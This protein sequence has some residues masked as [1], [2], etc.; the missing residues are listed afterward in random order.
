MVYNSFFLRLL[1]RVI[2][3]F[4]SLV[5]LSSIFLRTDLFFTQVILISL[6][7][8]QITELTRFVN[9]TNNELSRFLASVKDGDF[10]ASFSA[11]PGNQS[12]RTLNA[13]FSQLIETLKE[14]ETEKAAQFHFLNQLV[15]Q[16][17]FG[18]I[19]FNDKEEI[20]LMNQQACELL[21]FPKIRNWKNLK[22]PNIS[23]IRSLLHSEDSKR[24]LI[25][26]RIDE[27][28]NYFSVNSTIVKILD[29]RYKI[30]SFQDIRSEI[31]QKEIEAWHKLIRILTHE[32]MNSV[33][34]LVSLT[35]TVEMILTHNGSIIPL[36]ELDQEQMDDV[37]QA[38]H[39]IKDRSKG[40]LKFVQ[41][42]RKL[43]R[44]P[45]PE[46]ELVDCRN[47]ISEVLILIGSDIKDTQIALINEAQ[48]HK[49][50]V[51]QNLIQQVLINLLKNSVEALEE[52]EKGKILVST[53]LNRESFLIKVSD[54]GPGI[55]QSKTDRIF[56]PFYTTKENGSGIGLSLSR[57][58]LNLHG[59]HLELQSGSTQTTFIISLPSSLIA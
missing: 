39:T 35:E 21:S 59:G 51:D 15:D 42:Y 5:A 58:I 56:V 30:I 18:I 1:I 48:N 9:K 2:L 11:N 36:E 41:D 13:S 47:L 23:F 25:E 49:I 14:L 53:E 54:N 12:F 44:I 27:K 37:V 6:I 31:Q 28:I 32:T 52:T 24:H 46:F 50:N 3:L 19:T 34:P 45:Q 55:P 43:T 33:T 7:I 57:Q 40:I 8:G 20:E 17:E 10:S 16:I 22:N 38:I 29:K 4:A 26:Q